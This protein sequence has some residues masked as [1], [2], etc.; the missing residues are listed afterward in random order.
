MSSE[1]RVDGVVAGKTDLFY[2]RH[3]SH[4]LSLNFL[5]WPN[6][7]LRAHNQGGLWSCPK[8]KNQPSSTL[9]IWKIDPHALIPH[10]ASVPDGT[11]RESCYP[12][13]GSLLPYPPQYSLYIL[14]AD[15]TWTALSLTPDLPLDLP[16]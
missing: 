15:S 1:L 10:N 8:A 12:N 4:F 7:R 16:T 14:H 3:W 2:S 9:S 6:S 11:P 13:W 5:F